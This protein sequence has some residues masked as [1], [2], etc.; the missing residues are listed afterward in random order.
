M[1]ANRKSEKRVLSPQGDQV[2]QEG[3]I[4]AVVKRKPGRPPGTKNSKTKSNPVVINFENSEDVSEFEMN[5]DAIKKL[6]DEQFKRQNDRID[7]KLEKNNENLENLSDKFEQ[8]TELAKNKFEDLEKRIKVIENGPKNSSKSQLAAE[9]AELVTRGMNFLLFN[10]EEKSSNLITQKETDT[11]LV[12]DLFAQLQIQ[13][14]FIACHRLG[15]Y[16]SDSPRPRPL[17]CITS[18]SQ[19]VREVFLR[20][21][22]KD[23]L[24]IRNSSF[25]NISIDHDLTEAQQQQKKI[26]NEEVKSDREKNIHSQVRI[27]NHELRKV[28]KRNPNRSTNQVSSPSPTSSR[29]E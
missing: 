15:R 11:D 10:V 21:L 29:M 20:F 8:F 4:V 24:P 28:L 19:I 25:K 9:G 14:G 17:K 18:H 26:L 2:E 12:K 27:V 6:F 22:H 13:S 7:K 5:I 1:E 3:A 23:F 16:K